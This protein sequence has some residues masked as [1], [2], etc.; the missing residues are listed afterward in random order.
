MN[1]ASDTA[2]RRCQFCDSH[3]TRDFA[4]TFGDAENVAHRCLNC[5]TFGRVS[6]G[7]AAGRDISLPDPQTTPGHPVDIDVPVTD[8][9]DEV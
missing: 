3:V 9:G 7:S 8:G 2:S 6:S 1:W 4:R 5:D